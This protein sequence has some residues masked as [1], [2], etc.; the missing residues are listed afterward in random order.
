[1]NMINISTDVSQMN[2]FDS[3]L[4]LPEETP[5]DDGVIVVKHCNDDLI[6][7]E[8]IQWNEVDVDEL[9]EFLLKTSLHQ[10]GDKRTSLDTRI[11]IRAWIESDKVDE[12]FSFMNCC[13]A[14][15]VCPEEMMESL[16]YYTSSLNK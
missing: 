9:R 12:P 15:G 2:F 7:A 16:E 11:E 10:M 5:V 6:S 14:L 13:H 8:S 4:S 1:M 3:I